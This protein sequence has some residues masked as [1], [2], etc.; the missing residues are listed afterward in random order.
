MLQALELL[1]L[2][3]SLFL[4]IDPIC[5]L[6]PNTAVKLQN[7]LTTQQ[8]KITKQDIASIAPSAKVSDKKNTIA[9]TESKESKENK[10]EIV[11]TYKS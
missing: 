10:D 1:P 9:N 4:Q 6:K 7:E 11:K 5:L 2:P 3:C 8:N